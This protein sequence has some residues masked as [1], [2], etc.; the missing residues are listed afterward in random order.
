MD[1]IGLNGEEKMSPS[2]LIAQVKELMGL[3][4]DVG[5]ADINLQT[6]EAGRTV[7]HLALASEV[8][9]AFFFLILGGK[10]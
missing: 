8:R 1:T 9:P 7:F 2:V 6:T 5:A 4:L 10:M 3:F